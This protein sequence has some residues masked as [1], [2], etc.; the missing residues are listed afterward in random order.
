[1]EVWS[2]PLNRASRKGGVN[3]REEHAEHEAPTPLPKPELPLN[4]AVTEP[5]MAML[6]GGPTATFIVGNIKYRFKRHI[7]PQSS[8][9]YKVNSP[10]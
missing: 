2:I 4:G 5:V 7:Q 1:M 3:R 10:V 9:R 6:S 8:Q